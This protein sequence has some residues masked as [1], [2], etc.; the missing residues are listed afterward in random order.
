LWLTMIGAALA[1]VLLDARLVRFGVEHLDIQLAALPWLSFF[2]TVVMASGTAHAVNIID[3]YNGLAGTYIAGVLLAC[4]WVALRVN[5]T[6]IACLATGG[7]VVVFSFLAW[8]FPYGKIFLGDA[9]AYSL[10]LFVGLVLLALVARNEEVSP[11]FAAAL[12]CYPVWETLFSTYRKRRRGTSSSQPDRLHLHMLVY[13]RL[14]HTKAATFSSVL[15]N[16][17]TTIYL[18]PLIVGVP[19]LAIC[20][21]NRT[22][23]LVFVFVGCIAIYL[24][25]YSTLVGFAV[26]SVLGVRYRLGRRPSV[27][28][29]I[30]VSSD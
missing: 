1:W 5:D 19:I 30:S 6:E 3:G 21:W 17:A 27:P 16:S 4:L 15:L 26:P 29:A 11:M 28:H 2:F 18:L 13:K 14:V 9:G 23:L 25:I 10:G 22:F 7:L 24:A 12:L 8:N 20:F